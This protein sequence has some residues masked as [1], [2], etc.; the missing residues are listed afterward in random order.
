MTHPWRMASPPGLSRFSGLFLH[1]P[2]VGA[3]TGAYSAGP[4]QLSAVEL[5]P[6]D[7]MTKMEKARHSGDMRFL[8][9]KKNTRNFLSLVC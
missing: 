8:P 7:Q 3:G 5:T 9:D 1:G 6:T 2:L 4:E